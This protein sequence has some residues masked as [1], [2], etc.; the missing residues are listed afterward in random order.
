MTDTP[1]VRVRMAVGCRGTSNTAGDC[2]RARGAERI[3]QC[4]LTIGGLE[5]SVR[6]PRL[7]DP[8]RANGDALGRLELPG[9]PTFAAT[10][11]GLEGW[12]VAQLVSRLPL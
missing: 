11:Q 5:G 9:P 4:G 12:G 8:L 1:P 10:A 7:E 6:D 3:L 2:E